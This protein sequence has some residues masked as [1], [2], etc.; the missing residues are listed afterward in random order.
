[1]KQEITEDMLFGGTMPNVCAY[2]TQ[3]QIPRKVWE[4]F[5]KWNVQFYN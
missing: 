3:K 5:A 2:P 1:M 4:N